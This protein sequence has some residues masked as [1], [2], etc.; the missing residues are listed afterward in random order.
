MGLVMK[1]AR[2]CRCQRYRLVLLPLPKPGLR[3]L[4]QL[5]ALGAGAVRQREAE[6]A[7]RRKGGVQKSG[8][9]GR[10]RWARGRPR[11]CVFRQPSEKDSPSR[12]EATY[13]L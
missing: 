11:P 3:L 10:R 8:V 5:T 4:V 13:A 1:K 9:R 12:R 2:T 7:L 6:N